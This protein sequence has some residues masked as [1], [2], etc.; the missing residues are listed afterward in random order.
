MKLFKF[1][2]KIII[3]GKGLAQRAISSSFWI[4]F[5]NVTKEF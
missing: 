3:P 2:K 4:I 5:L 1:F